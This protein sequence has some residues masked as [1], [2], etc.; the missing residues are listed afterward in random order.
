MPGRG[1]CTLC[2]PCHI[3]SREALCGWLP[4]LPSIMHGPE[5]YSEGG[6]EF[7]LCSVTMPFCARPPFAQQRSHG[8]PRP[9]VDLEQIARMWHRALNVPLVGVGRMRAGNVHDIEAFTWTATSC[10]LAHR[11]E[12]Q[13]LRGS[14]PKHGIVG[15]LHPIHLM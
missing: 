8:R 1:P 12:R 4:S 15:L 10:Q 9:K 5:S 7:P 13:S 14:P 3:P 2:K 6:A 11:R